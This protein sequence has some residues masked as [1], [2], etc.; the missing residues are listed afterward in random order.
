MAD[1]DTVTHLFTLATA[2][3][4]AAEAMYLILAQRFAPYPEVARFWHEM[5][6]EETVHARTLERL[7][8][9]QASEVLDSPADPCMLQKAERNAHEDIIERARR[10]SDLEEAY[11]LAHAV[12][13][14]EV[15][16]VS[17]LLLTTFPEDPASGQFLRA[18][19]HEHV[20]RLM[21]SFPS[22]YSEVI[23]RRAALP[24][25]HL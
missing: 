19:L 10:V 18:Q 16:A 17:E 4:N 5:A 12:E 6:H 1:T 9:L 25:D 21:T 20:Q 13:N 14:S 15:N 3:E 24:V 11:Q 8:E 7:R 22:A 23:T 2:A